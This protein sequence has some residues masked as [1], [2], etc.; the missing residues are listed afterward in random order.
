MMSQT[1][2]DSRDP[3]THAIIGAAMEVHRQLG[4]G[5]LEAV[6]QEALALEFAAGGIPFAPQVELPVYYKGQ[7]LTCFYKADFVCY[8]SVILELKALKAITGVEESQLL[9]YLKATRLERG[10]LLN[11]GRPSLEFKRFVFSNPRKQANDPQITQ[12]HAD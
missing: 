9:N 2:A 3:Q 12:I 4:P 7:K 8:E 10:L 5:F 6:Y 1:N 11:F